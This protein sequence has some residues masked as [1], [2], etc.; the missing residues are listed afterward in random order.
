MKGVMASEL[1]LDNRQWLRF[2][3]NSYKKDRVFN[4]GLS[5]RYSEVGIFR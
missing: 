1:V 3:L 2:S 4:C 5:E